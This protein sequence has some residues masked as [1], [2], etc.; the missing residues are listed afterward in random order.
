MAHNTGHLDFFFCLCPSMTSQEHPQYLKH[1]SPLRSAISHPTT[2][3]KSPSSS[4]ARQSS[5]HT[6]E[7]VSSLIPV[8]AIGSRF[9]RHLTEGSVWGFYMVNQIVSFHLWRRFSA[10]PFF[11]SSFQRWTTALELR[12]YWER[13]VE[14]IQWLEVFRFSVHLTL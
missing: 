4:V 12:V 6:V 10:R 1:V 3:H 2:L 7:H 9:Y 8:G 11:K 5:T 14:S 13:I